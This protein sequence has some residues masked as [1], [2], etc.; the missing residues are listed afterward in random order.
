MANLNFYFT[1]L[2]QAL[3]VEAAL[4]GIQNLFYRFTV[5][6]LIYALLVIYSS[7]TFHKY[8]PRYGTCKSNRKCH[9]Y[10]QAKL[11]VA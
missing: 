3:V 8:F 5:Q 9:L 6:S 11:S 10:C 2:I 4:Y 1:E 7:T